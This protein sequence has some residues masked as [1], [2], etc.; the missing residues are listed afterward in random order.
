MKHNFFAHTFM[1]QKLIRCIILLMQFFVYNAGFSQCVP[2]AP[3]NLVQNGG[4]EN[5]I[6]C[7]PPVAGVING[8]FNTLCVPGWASANGTPAICVL[9]PQSYRELIRLAWEVLTL[10]MLVAEMRPFFK[11]SLYAKDHF[12]TFL[13][14]FEDY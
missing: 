5:L 3:V 6:N 13:Y 2:P 1:H 7:A 11:T 8:A 10:V 14:K 12:T 4:F 9:P